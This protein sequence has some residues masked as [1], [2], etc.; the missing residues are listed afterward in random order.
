MM[1][2]ILRSAGKGGDNKSSCNNFKVMGGEGNGDSCPV[3]RGQARKTEHTHEVASAGF[4]LYECC[5]S[6]G[7]VDMYGVVQT[8]AFEFVLFVRMLYVHES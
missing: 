2:R 8:N 7:V 6:G 1:G 4:I 3:A 5:K